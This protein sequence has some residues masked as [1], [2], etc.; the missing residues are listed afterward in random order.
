MS[1]YIAD[2]FGYRA[3]DQSETAK[4]YA[5]RKVCPVLGT[6]CTKRL[7]RDRDASGACAVRQATPGKPDVICCPIRL[8]ADDYKLL[9]I[10]SA[11]AFQ[12]EL[13][14]YAGRVAV[15]KAIEENGAVAVFGHGWGGELQLPQRNGQG[16]YSVDW[17]LARLDGEGMLA[18]ISAIEVQT[19]DTTGN[20]HDSRDALLRNRTMVK[21]TVGLNWEN[22]SKRILPQIIYKGQVLQRESLCRTGL[23]FVCPQPVFERVIDRL[24]GRNNLPE[25]PAGQPG[26]VHFFS[27]DFNHEVDAV[28]GVMRPLAFREEYCT[29]VH[30]VQEAFSN[31]ALPETNVYKSAIER[32]L[33]GEVTYGVVE[34]PSLL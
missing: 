19:I 31:I 7:G 32:A 3:E 6:E 34:V 20:Y 24:G 33:Y 16:S 25:F 12:C 2:F 30:K 29:A 23:Y 22:V 17:M 10:I 9:K 11:R 4:Q 13:N 18:E 1:G 27:Y 14:L 8:Y 28:D 21:S 15:E 26:T 5:L